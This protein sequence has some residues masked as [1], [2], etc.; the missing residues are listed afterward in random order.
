MVVIQDDNYGNHAGGGKLVHKILIETYYWPAMHNDTITCALKWD[1]CQRF[2]V[3][4]H[5]TPSGLTTISSLRPFAQY[6]SNV[7][8]PTPAAPAQKRFT[9]VATDYFTKWV[10]AEAYANVKVK[11]V[12]NFLWKNN[13]YCFRVPHCNTSRKMGKF[14]YLLSICFIIVIAYNIDI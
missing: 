11:D 8:D 3:I 14:F 6:G 12:R 1:K 13:V 7:V 4:P 10:E 9:L 2:A 5:Q